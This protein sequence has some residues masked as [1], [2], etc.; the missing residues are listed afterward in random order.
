MNQKMKGY[1]TQ[2]YEQGDGIN[3]IPWNSEPK[4]MQEF[5]MNNP[6]S[7][8]QNLPP[9]TK[10]AMIARELEIKSGKIDFVFVNEYG[11]FYIVETKLKINTDKKEIF[12]QVD[13]YASAT[14]N[15]LEIEKDI[16]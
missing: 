9:K 4:E 10:I 16:D 3:S 6:T 1:F 14:W 7:I 13:Y 11:D 12:A 2:F 8:F 5:V 15:K